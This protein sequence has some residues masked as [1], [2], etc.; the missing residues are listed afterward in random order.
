MALPTTGPLSGSQ[1]GAELSL[2]PSNLS[3]NGMIDS[4][5]L[6]NTNPDAYSDFYGYS[7]VT[8]TAVSSSLPVNKPLLGCNTSNVFQLFHDGDFANPQ[9]G[10][11]LYSTNS[12]SNPVGA[13]NWPIGLI[14][15]FKTVYTTNSSGVI[16]SGFSCN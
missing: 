6:S 12:T 14:P 1:I 11:T 3:L 8:L 13:D 15:E 7:N 9:P 10:D 16:T 5:S 2:L 4:S